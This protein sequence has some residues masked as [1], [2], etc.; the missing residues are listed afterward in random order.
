MIN[1]KGF[2]FILLTSALV[3]CISVITS[4]N[5]LA[6]T[7]TNKTYIVK[8]G[9]CLSLIANNYGETLNN[10]RISNNKWNDLILPGQILNV[11]AATSSVV[12]KDTQT[13]GVSAKTYTVKSKDNLS[14]IAKKYGMSLDNLKKANNKCS[15][16][17]FPGQILNVSKTTNSTAVQ[18]SKSKSTS[19][20]VK[21]ISSSVINYSPS[22]LDLLARL[23]T[24]EAQGEPY[25]AQVAVGAVVLNRV[26]SSSF[27]NSI[28]AVINQHTNGCYQFT[29]VLNGNINR[30]AKESALKAAYEALSGNDPTNK[31]LFF[32]DDTATDTWIRSQPVS[33]TIN[34]LTFVH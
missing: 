14:S 15:N 28:S 33:I 9:D 18:S 19:S 2:R 5:I 8:S 17:I 12:K 27:P 13:K 7:L 22:D 24:A 32:Y 29:P 10:L 6:A 25:N 20:I 34:K 31:A 30:P 21:K 26:K 16:T 3:I 1:F 4:Q 11:S 23:I